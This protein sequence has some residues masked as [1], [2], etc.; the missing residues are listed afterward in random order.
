MLQ[1]SSV[2]HSSSFKHMDYIHVQAMELMLVEALIKADSYLK[3]SSHILTPAEYWKVLSDCT[4]YAH[5]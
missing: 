2:E 5:A 4:C 1:Y 3:I